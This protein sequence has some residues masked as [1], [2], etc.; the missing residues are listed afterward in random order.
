VNVSHSQIIATD[1]VEA[2]SNQSRLCCA[3]KP[4][5]AQLVNKCL[6]F[7][8]LQWI[9]TVFCDTFSMSKL[10]AFRTPISRFF[11]NYSKEIF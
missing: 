11:R 9:I 3:E 10:N 4:K 6:S 8:G 7:G 1:T 5:F 2:P